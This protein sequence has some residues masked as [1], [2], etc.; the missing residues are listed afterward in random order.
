MPITAFPIA[1][2]PLSS[3]VD[4]F[5]QSS[6]QAAM[7]SNLGILGGTNTWTGVNQFNNR[8]GLTRS[9]LIGAGVTYLLDG[10]YTAAPAPADQPFGAKVTLLFNGSSTPSASQHGA[11][12]L[13]WGQDT[14]LN[15]HGLIGVEGKVDA[16][17]LAVQYIGVSGDAGFIGSSF[18]AQTLF[19]FAVTRMSITTDGTTP[20]AS[21]TAVGLYVPT[22]VGGALKLGIYSKEQVR[23]DNTITAYSPAGAGG[24]YVAHNGTDGFCAT[25]SGNL[26]IIANSGAS[27][28]IAHSLGIIPD[29]E[30][31][32]LGIH[33]ARWAGNF[34]S[35]STISLAASV[36]P[37]NNTELMFQATSNTSLTFKYKGSDGTVRSASLTLA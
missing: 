37:A 4:T 33:G 25:L 24:T 11:A 18:T 17:G 26:R 3:A 15:R 20:L 28:I 7:L 36:T 16:T 8:I 32:A 22:F 27:A 30:G 2:I 23:V 9:S 1:T 31:T 21:G 34:T 29:I 13:G 12:F 19:G 10:S 14:A 35:L 5:L 6:N